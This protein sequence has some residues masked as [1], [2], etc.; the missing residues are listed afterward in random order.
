M[1]GGEFMASYVCKNCSDNKW[2]GGKCCRFE[3]S[4][5]FSVVESYDSSELNI[6]REEI[7]TM[8][9]SIDNIQELDKF[10]ILDVEIQNLKVIVSEIE[11]QITTKIEDEWNEISG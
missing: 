1:I 2:N 8:Q 5:P 9:K 10:D 6:F 7:N 4:C 3:Y 11:E